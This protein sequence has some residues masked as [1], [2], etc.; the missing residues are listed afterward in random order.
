MIRME[1]HN[2][3]KIWLN[4]ENVIIITEQVEQADAFFSVQMVT[5][6]GVEELKL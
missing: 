3:A 6:R 4:V 1:G 2:N 5:L